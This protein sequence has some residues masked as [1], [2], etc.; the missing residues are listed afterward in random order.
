MKN[1][2]Y[3]E[4]VCP[5]CDT[6]NIWTFG[7]CKRELMVKCRCLVTD[8]LVGNTHIIPQGSLVIWKES[9]DVV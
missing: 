5:N 1:I 8:I 7:N 2:K 3:R 9:K 6:S 4:H